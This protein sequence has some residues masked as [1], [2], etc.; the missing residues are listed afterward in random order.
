MEK[1]RFYSMEK[2][3]ANCFLCNRRCKIAE[4]ALG[5]C[6]VR[7]NVGGEL[8]SLVYGKALT[9]AVDPIEKKP[10]FNFMPG[11][12]CNSV[13]TYGCNFKCEFCQNHSTS[14]DFAEESISATKGISPEEIVLNAIAAGSEGI[15]YTYV[16]P[17]IF[18]EYAMDTMKLARKEGLYNVWVSNGYMSLEAAEEIAENLDAINIDLKG[19]SEFYKKLCGNVKREHV[20]ESIKFFHKK[21]CM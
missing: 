1:A 4:G 17:T 5:Y 3:T 20:L 15:A 8:Q 7:K 14:Q 12:F 19:N 10:I 2:G 18:A 21:K 6:R 16:E 13:S 11:T 9:M